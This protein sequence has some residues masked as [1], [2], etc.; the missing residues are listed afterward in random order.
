MTVEPVAHE[1][2]SSKKLTCSPT[3]KI[4]IGIGCGIT[5]FAPEI[6]AVTPLPPIT[7][8]GA[9][10]VPPLPGVTEGETT[11]SS[12]FGTNGIASGLNLNFDD[13][14]VVV[15]ED[16]DERAVDFVTVA[17]RRVVEVGTSEAVVGAES[18]SPPF[19]D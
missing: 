8:T 6:C 10:T 12:F 2:I 7:I 5:L 16:E 1:F 17:I 3:G 11:L 9:F 15:E 14:V 13:D 19:G 18:L 4:C